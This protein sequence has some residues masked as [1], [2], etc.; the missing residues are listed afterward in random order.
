MKKSI[1]N[2]GKTLN[3]T[4]QKEIKGSAMQLNC[5]GGVE[6]SRKHYC[7]PTLGCVSI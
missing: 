7:H 3:K 2:L 5:G 4:E 1:S 6:C